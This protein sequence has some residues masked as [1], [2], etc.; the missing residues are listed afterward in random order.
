MMSPPGMR[1]PT[2][3]KPMLVSSRAVCATEP[4]SHRAREEEGKGDCR[5]SPFSL[6]ALCLRSLCGHFFYSGVAWLGIAQ[7]DSDRSRARGPAKITPGGKR[8]DEF[9]ERQ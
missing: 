4:E 2:S 7:H 8:Y 6:S 1:K 3:T 9:I 5:E